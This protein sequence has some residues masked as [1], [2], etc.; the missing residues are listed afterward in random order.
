VSLKA[1]ATGKQKDLKRQ[2]LYYRYYEFVRDHTVI[3]HLAVRGYQHK[4]IYFHTVN[5]W[6][7][8]DL[9]KDPHEQTNLIKSPQHQKIVQQLKAELLKLREQYNDHEAAGELK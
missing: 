1:L 2:Y 6:E 3:P 4:L 5:E 9:K 7:L 8:Y